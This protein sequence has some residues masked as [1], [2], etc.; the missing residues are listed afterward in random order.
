LI[1][2]AESPQI[3]QMNSSSE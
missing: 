3:H 2:I 1:A